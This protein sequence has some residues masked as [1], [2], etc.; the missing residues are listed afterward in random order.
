MITIKETTFK[1]TTVQLDRMHY[2]RCIFDECVI[3]YGGGQ[4]PNL[5]DNEFKNCSWQFVGSAQN[6]LQFMN[7]IYFGGGKDLI[8]N[9]FNEVR[10][11]AKKDPS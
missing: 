2:E 5:V 7:G 4:P 9:I 11:P 1:G 6:T 3:T 8:E 10:Q